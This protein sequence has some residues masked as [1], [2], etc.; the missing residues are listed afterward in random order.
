MYDKAIEKGLE[1]DFIYLYKGL[2]L[3][4]NQQNEEAIE[5]FKIAIE[6]NPKGQTNHTELGN[7]YYFKEAY[8]EALIHFKN[9]RALPYELGDPYLKLPNIYHIQENFEKAL[10]EYRISAE[11][12]HKE[13][14]IYPELFKE[15]GLLEYT[16]FKNYDKSIAAYQKVI[17]LNPTDYDFYPKLIK[18]YYAKEDFTKGDSLFNI[19]KREFENGNLSEDFTKFG[20]VPIA[21]F[22]WNDQNIAVYKNLETPKKA[23]DLMYKIYLI[24]KDLSLIHI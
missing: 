22:K 19:L 23:L 7:S 24:S 16:V 5:H 15:I 10:E 17:A 1:E 9:A 11:L 8:E 14:P 13:D 6:K 2:S 21:E 18:S 20:T 3:R 12:I 4:Y